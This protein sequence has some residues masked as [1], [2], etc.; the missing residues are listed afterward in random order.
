MPL[1][2][3]EVEGLLRLKDEFTAVLNRAEAAVGEFTAKSTKS[4]Q[5]VALKAGLSILSFEGVRKVSQALVT[6]QIEVEKVNAQVEQTIR[7]V[8]AASG[9]TSEKVDALAESMMS[10]TGV[11]DEVIKQSQVILMTMGIQEEQF[12]RTSQAALDLSVRM[13][14]GR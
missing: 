1:S 5:D 13:G 10:L 12:A 14:G 6:A 3:G 2:I 4:F 9:Y 11:D 8:G 7:S